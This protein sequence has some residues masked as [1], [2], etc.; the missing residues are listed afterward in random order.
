MGTPA[1]FHAASGFRERRRAV[2]ARLAAVGGAAVRRPPPPEGRLGA[3]DYE[4]PRV[5]EALMDLGPVFA[6]FGRYLATRLDLISRRDAFELLVI[7]D[8]ADP[9]PES[10]VR[11]CVARQLGSPL[12]HRFFAFE[13]RARVAAV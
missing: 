9:L 3:D 6:S 8:V 1:P 13:S 7:P 10:E 4:M 5:A 12:E 2:E 11:A